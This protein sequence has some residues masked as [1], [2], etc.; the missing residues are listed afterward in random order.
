[1]DDDRVRF[2]VSHSEDLA[3]YAM[4]S[5]F[6]CGVDLE[7]HRST[8][9]LD[10]LVQHFF[11]HA[12]CRALAALNPR[13]RSEAFFRCWV[14]KEAVIKATGLGLALALHSF[15]VPIEADGLPC[16]TSAQ[17]TQWWLYE[18]P[19]PSGYSGAIAVGSPHARLVFHD[20]SC[21]A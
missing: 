20:L 21:G 18:V 15:D 11:S 17:G 9:D 1:L 4:S 13:D 19:V 8:A 16:V 14:R 2:N 3:L 5:V 7:A 10:T 12:E 6:D